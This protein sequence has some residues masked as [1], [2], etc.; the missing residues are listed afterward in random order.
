MG[1]GQTGGKTTTTPWAGQQPYLSDLFKQGQQNYAGGGPSYF[2]DQTY[3]PFSPQQQQAFGATEQRAYGSPTEG[4]FNQYLQQSLGQGQVDLSGAAQ[5]A[6]QL[7]GG[8]GGGL[9]QLG[10]TARGDYLNSNPYLDQMFSAA[11]RPITQNYEN[12]VNPGINAA[13]GAASRTGSGIQGEYLGDA[14]GQYGKSLSDL[15]ANIYGGNYANERQNQLGAA[16]QLGQLGLGGIGAQGSLY[17]QI[18]ADQG[19]AGAFAPQASQIDWNN[20]DR[21]AGVGSAVQQQG[22]LGINDAMSRYNFGQMSP[23]QNLQNYANLIYGLPGGYGTQTNPNPQGSPTTGAIGG[24][25]AGAAAGNQI[26]PGYGALIGG[27]LGA[28]GGYQ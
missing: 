8:I 9:S 12:V 10:Q 7:T 4:A 11:S 1:G 25:I 13:F 21:L 5:G 28:V 27:L 15:S 16:G 2:P 20:I 3:A 26:Y 24:G 17:G 6:D 19:R 22:Q 23:Y 18:S 14:A